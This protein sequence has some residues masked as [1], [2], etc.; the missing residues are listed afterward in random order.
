MSRERWD[1]SLTWMTERHGM[2]ALAG[3]LREAFLDYLAAAFGPRAAPGQV[4]RPFL[5]APQ[6]RNPFAPGDAAPAAR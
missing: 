1:E 5:V 3:E 2:G 4:P 6:R